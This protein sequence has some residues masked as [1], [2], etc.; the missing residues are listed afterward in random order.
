M[1]INT[2]SE[3]QLI[4]L[5]SHYKELQSDFAEQARKLQ[6]QHFGNGVFIRGL[7]EVSS[8]CR[9]DCFYCGIRK[10]NSSAQR[11]HLTDEQIFACCKNGYESGFR[12]FVLQGG[13]DLQF[14]AQGVATLISKI[15]NLYSDC[16]V[17]LSLGERDYSTYK[18]WRQAG[19]DRY[20]LR[21]EAADSQLYSKLHPQKQK[22][23]YRKQCLFDLKELGFQVGSGFMVG[24][25]FQT[26]ENLAQDILF[27][28]NLQPQMIGIGPFI[29]H[30]ATPFADFPAG[31]VELTLF[32][33]SLLRL[34]FPNALIPA[35]TALNA[36][37]KTGRIDGIR[38]GA[39]V[40]MPN[41]SPKDVRKK[42]DL[43]EGKSSSG[44]ESSEGLKNLMLEMEKINYRI[45]LNERGD[46]KD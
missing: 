24:A 34:I 10:S 46:F 12:T 23:E 27:L 5:I 20:L 33:I 21:H 13:E 19:A 42:Y 36:L 22:L 37:S 45:L 1:L 38:A 16:A 32:L 9:C 3:S 8:Y 25:P 40:V 15:K 44:I 17:T 28:E 35:T 14:S 29:P 6:Q 7:I 41:L 2:Y 4:D 31:N 11:Y 30:K 26:S 39:N 43:Y 18:L